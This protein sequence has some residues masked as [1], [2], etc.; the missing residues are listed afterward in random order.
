MIEN[1]KTT[2]YKDNTAI[3]NL[4][5]NEDWIADLTGAYCWHSN[6]ITNKNPYGALYN[7][8]AVNNAHGLA[9]IGWRVATDADF[10]TLVSYLGGSVILAGG[11]LKEIDTTHWNTPNT[12][13]VNEINFTALP[14]GWRY[15]SDATFYPKG[16]YFYTWSSIEYN[17]DDG[18]IRSISYNSAQFFGAHYDKNYGLSVRCVKNV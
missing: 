16:N 18:Y 7:W 14:G 15:Q 6:D 11:K 10:D 9:P 2:K 17:I 4:T 5:V 13:A 1:L 12:G 8:F 3:P